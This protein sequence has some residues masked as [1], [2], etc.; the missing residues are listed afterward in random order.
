MSTN[1]STS[2]TRLN[3]IR[4]FAGESQARSRYTLAQEKAQQQ[5]QYVISALFKFTADQEKAHAKVFYEHLSEL[6]GSTIKVD[7]GYPVDISS[8]L[9]DLLKM[10]A[11]NED[12]EADD[13]YPAFAETARAEGFAKVAQDFENIAQIERSHSAR[14]KKFHDLCTSGRL[15]FLRQAR[16]LGL[17]EL[18]IYPRKRAGTAEMS[19]LRGRS[20]LLYPP[21][22]GSVGTLTEKRRCKKQRS[23]SRDFLLLG[24]LDSFFMPN[25]KNN[26]FG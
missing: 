24:N 23:K 21:R 2:E 4:A 12:Q 5:G 1:F 17:H 25:R 11:H 3:L 18:R 19:R 14:F 20:G 7:G 6:S 26:Y 9:C 15:F 10:A 13:V 22:D 16:A 8:R